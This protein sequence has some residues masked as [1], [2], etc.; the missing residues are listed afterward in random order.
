L[1]AVWTGSLTIET[2]I[3]VGWYQAND[4]KRL[5]RHQS[6]YKSSGFCDYGIC[7]GGDQAAE[8]AARRTF[9]SEPILCPQSWIGHCA[10]I[11]NGTRLGLVAREAYARG[12]VRLKQWK[13]A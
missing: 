2:P 13:L 4:L 1:E 5:T 8:D 3:R 6:Q 12:A 11:S 7:V 10:T 9:T